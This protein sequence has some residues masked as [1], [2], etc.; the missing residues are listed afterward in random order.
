MTLG[1]LREEVW[2]ALARHGLALHPT[3]PHGHHPNFLGGRRAAERLLATPEFLGARLLLVGMD[4]V[5]K[6]LREEA[7][8]RG[9][10]LLLPHPD[11]PGEFLLLKDLDPRRLKRVREAYRFGVKAPLEGQPIDLVLIGAVAVDE[12]GG[13]VGKGYGFPQAWLRVAAPF[14]TLAHPLM[15]YPRLPVTPERRVDL[16]ATPERLIRP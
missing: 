3:P 14:A 12:E 5:L 1:E 11:R 4:A 7:L 9:K 2:N 8:R 15:V 13:W 16:I 10:A 6:P